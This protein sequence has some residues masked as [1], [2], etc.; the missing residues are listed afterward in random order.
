MSD[1]DFRQEVAAAVLENARSFPSQ[2]RSQIERAPQGTVIRIRPT[3]S[4]S[5][6]GKEVWGLRVEFRWPMT[7][8]HSGWIYYRARRAVEGDDTTRVGLLLDDELAELAQ[9]ALLRTG[10]EACLLAVGRR[11]REVLCAAA[12][13]ETSYNPASFDEDGYPIAQLDKRAH[14]VISGKA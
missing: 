12:E 14:P 2:C 8:A 6:S 11:A 7:M 10:Q 1:L 4:T 9:F 3:A 13:A 5:E